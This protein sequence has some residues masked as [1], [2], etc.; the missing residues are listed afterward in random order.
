MWFWKKNYYI[1]KRAVLAFHLFF[2]VF[3]NYIIRTSL[4]FQIIF[5][6]Q[7]KALPN[8]SIP[9]QENFGPRYQW[10]EVQQSMILGS[11]YYGY[12]IAGLFAGWFAE[13]LDTIQLISW[14]TG[15]QCIFDLAIPYIA[16]KGWVYVM[17]MRIMCGTFG[18]VLHPANHTLVS[19]WAPP[20]ERGKFISMLLGGGLGTFTANVLL[21]LLIPQYGYGS[22]FWV[23]SAIALLWALTFSSYCHQSPAEHPYISKEERE[24]IE[25]S[26]SGLKLHAGIIVHPPYRL[27]FTNIHFLALLILHFGSDFGLFFVISDGPKFASEGLKLSYA[28]SGIFSGLPGLFRLVGGICFGILGDLLHRKACISLMNLRRIFT[29]FSHILPGI[30]IVGVSF[31]GYKEKYFAVCLL[32]FSM[33]SNGASILTNNANIQD[34]SPNFAGTLFGYCNTVGGIAGVTMP[35]IAG[36]FLAG[37][38]GNSLGNWDKAFWTVAGVFWITATVWIIFGAA[39][40][41]EFNYHQTGKEIINLADEQKP[42]SSHRSSL[43]E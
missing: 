21:G 20:T 42:T 25:N 30:F 41:Q 43:Q 29:I 24:Y 40:I 34:L 28:H 15:L 4:S 27:I 13:N 7:A 22:S 37:Q 18:G 2:S 14:T 36:Y 8:G 38:K 10:G 16:D 5:M 6:T 23:V 11:Y 17:V 9:E 1:P 33:G 31:C 32:A 19:K 39:R 3:V 35:L 12:I 26:L